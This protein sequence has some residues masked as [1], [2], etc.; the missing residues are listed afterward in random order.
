MEFPAEVKKK[1]GGLDVDGHGLLVG[2]QIS[3]SSFADDI[4]AVESV[5]W[6]ACSW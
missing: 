4:S 5:R 2:I 6:S 3:A 1:D